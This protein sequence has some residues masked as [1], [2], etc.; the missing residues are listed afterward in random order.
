[1]TM[2]S[3]V[4]SSARDRAT[5][6]LSA[7][8]EYAHDSNPAPVPLHDSDNAQSIPSDNDG[9][10]AKVESWLSDAREHLENFRI[11]AKNK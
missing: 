3:P 1:M 6:E 7:V 4:S 11:F 5:E 2:F 9:V 10:N 8:S